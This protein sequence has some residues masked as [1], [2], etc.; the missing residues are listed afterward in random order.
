MTRDRAAQTRSPLSE[1]RRRSLFVH[2]E[3]VRVTACKDDRM[4]LRRDEV[5]KLLQRAGFSEAAEAAE[6]S[7]PDSVDLEDAA[8]FGERYGVTRDS[9]IS[10][11]GGSP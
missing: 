5:V 2:G 7:L 1:I 4:E 8:K 9:L 6:R 10:R 3:R 11:M